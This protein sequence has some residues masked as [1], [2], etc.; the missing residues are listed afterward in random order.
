[1]KNRFRIFLV[2]SLLYAMFIFYLSSNSSLGNPRTILS[3]FHF[4]YL[5]NLLK[6]I[7]N[8]DLRFLSF[9]LYISYVKGVGVL[10]HNRFG[11]H[12]SCF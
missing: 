10:P 9:P 12:I 6:P 7:E 11:Y 5:R 8:S 3:F 4:E 2:L 1:M